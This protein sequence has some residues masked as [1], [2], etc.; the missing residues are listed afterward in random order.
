[1]F[2]KRKSLTLVLAAVLIFSGLSVGCGGNNVHDF[3]VDLNKSAATLNAAAKEN[4]TLYELKVFGANALAIRQKAAKGIYLANESLIVALDV[5]KNMNA[6]TFTGD[7]LQ[8]LTLLGQA[9]SELATAHIGDARVDALLQAAAATINSV[10]VVVTALSHA[11]L[12]IPQRIIRSE[13]NKQLAS[14]AVV[15]EYSFSDMGG[16]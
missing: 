11:D 13:I 7:K 14:F 16:R 9:V 2:L 6:Q 15:R 1:M 3:K 5:A 12:R 4:R 10:I 8:I